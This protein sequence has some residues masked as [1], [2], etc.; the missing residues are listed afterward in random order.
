MFYDGIKK[1]NTESLGIAWSYDLKTWHEYENNPVIIS[2]TGWRSRPYCSEP[3]WIGKC[4]NVICVM[5]AGAKDFKAGPWHHYITKR[6]YKDISGNVDDMQLGLFLSYDG[7][8]SFVQHCLNPLLVN[9]YANDDENEHLGGSLDFIQ[10]NDTLFMFY[11]GKTTFEN[12]HYQPLLR[13]KII[14]SIL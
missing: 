6:M 4:G 8:R 11:I 2:H 5:L 3:A 9:D 13:Y 1:N 12:L 7:G 10:K 14:D